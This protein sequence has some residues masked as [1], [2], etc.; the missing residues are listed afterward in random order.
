MTASSGPSIRYLYARSV[1]RAGNIAVS[2]QQSASSAVITDEGGSEVNVV[3]L[4]GFSG[5]ESQV[6]ADWLAERVADGQVRWVLTDSTSSSPADG[7]TGSTDVM[8]AVAS[9][10]EPVEMDSGSGASDSGT[11]NSGSGSSSVIY[12]CAGKASELASE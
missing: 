7:R 1:D 8:A 9:V 3:A 6:S 12:D 11:S 4:G 2:G 10:C 5:R